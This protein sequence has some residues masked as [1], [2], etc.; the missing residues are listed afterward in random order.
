MLKEAVFYGIPRLIWWLRQQQ[1]LEV[2]NVSY[3]ITAEEVTADP[4]EI[5]ACRSAYNQHI[6]TVVVQEKE[7]YFCPTDATHTQPAHCSGACWGRL[8]DRQPRWIMRD[9]V[10]AIAEC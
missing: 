6:S 9:C 7:R 1:Y 8:G 4:V 2:V 3:R 5:R 10:K